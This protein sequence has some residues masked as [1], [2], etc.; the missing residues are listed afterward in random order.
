LLSIVA[1]TLWHGATRRPLPP[2]QGTEL[3]RHN[4]AVANAVAASL[5][6]RLAAFNIHSGRGTDGF[7]DLHRTAS[8][9][10]HFDIIGLN[11]VRGVRFVQSDMDTLAELLEM[12]SLFAPAERRW[13]VDEFGNGALCRLPVE[14][15]RH[16]PLLGAKRGYG[17]RNVLELMV[18]WNNRFL[19]VL[20]TH[21]DRSHDRVAQL[22]VL[23][24]MFA[25]VPA[26][27][28][29]IG[30]LN[31]ARGDAALNALFKSTDTADPIAARFQPPTPGRIDWILT[32]G[33]DAVA[34]GVETQGASDH[35]MVW[36][37]LRLR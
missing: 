35:P 6:L 2:A 11:E 1:I 28:V 29:L 20:I 13:W 23:G 36:A 17:Y 27:A 10:Q 34:A 32:R 12:P 26:P 14:Y 19:T 37:E 5:T 30:D 31:T 15:W 24:K 8:V 22:G 3:F 9:L 4:P 33:L 25:S 7:R 18:R 16:T 21:L